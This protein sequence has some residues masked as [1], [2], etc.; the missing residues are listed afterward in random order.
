MTA[1]TPVPTIN[2]YDFWTA[3]QF[4][5]YIRDN[6]AALSGGSSGP[7]ALP[8][9]VATTSAGIRTGYTL[10]AAN[11]TTALASGAKEVAFV[12]DVTGNF[13]VPAG[14]TLRGS[15]YSSAITG[16]LTNNGA[17]YD[18]L[19]HGHVSNADTADNIWI[20]SS[21]GNLY[22]QTGIGIGRH[23]YCINTGSGWSMYVTGGELDRC[24]TN[25]GTD[26][27]AKGCYFNNS[28]GR[29]KD[30]TF[31]GAIIGLQLE[32]ALYANGILAEVYQA[33]ATGAL[34]HTTGTAPLSNSFFKDRGGSGYALNLAAGGLTFTDCG[35]EGTVTGSGAYGLGDRVP[36][37]RTLTVPA[38]LLI[39]AAASADL[40]ADRTLTWAA[41][42]ANTFLAGPTTGAD[43]ALTVRA[44]V[45]A[46][47]PTMAKLGYLYLA[48]TYV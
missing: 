48:A 25:T 27:T 15:I 22:T 36:G 31:Q 8:G 43:A 1:Y 7:G 46:D 28:A 30:C 29:I 18:L 14:T 4:N 39:D 10:S 17:I 38:P 6:F 26:P 11:L 33:G 45:D 13:T 42:P 40:S 12:G 47:L 3:D 32:N 24:L 20:D 34:Y 16:D 44:L 37:N 41:S 19:V 5:T 23:I 9:I 21:S 2:S 35:W